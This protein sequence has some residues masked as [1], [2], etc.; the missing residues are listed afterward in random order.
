MTTTHTLH[1]DEADIA[2]DVHGPLPTVDRRPALFMIG[3]PMTASGFAT[4]VSYFPDR[5]VVTYGPRAAADSGAPRR[6]G[7]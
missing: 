2:Y 1:T 6:R 7:R 4:L 3:Q 5:T